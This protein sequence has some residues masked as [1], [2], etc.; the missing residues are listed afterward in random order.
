MKVTG[1]NKRN[2]Q[3]ELDQLLEHTQKEEKV[4][5]LFLHSCCAPCSSYVLEYLSQY[6]EITV[7][8]YNPNISLEEEYRKRV[9]EIQRLVAEMSFTHPVHIMEGTYDPQIFYEMARGLEKIPEGGERC[10]KCYRLRMEEAAKLAKEGNYD[11]FTTTLSISP[12]KNAEKINEIGEA[13]AEIYGV[14]HLPSDFKKKNGYKRSIELSHDYG[15]YRQNYCGCVFSK[16]EQEEKM[17][18]KQ[19]S[20]GSVL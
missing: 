20:E 14:K 17:K 16:R 13:L 11:Y 9:A 1:L 3:R 2:Y 5:R 6:F 4:P 12:L 19:I 18:Q 8:F 7:F 15:L 10:F